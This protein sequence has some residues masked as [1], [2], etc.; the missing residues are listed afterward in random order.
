MLA[1]LFGGEVVDV[2]F[3]RLNE[4]QSPLVELAEVVGGVAEALPLEAEPA[5]VGHDGVDVLLL[6]LF[7]IG[8][9]E[10]QVGFAAELVGETEVDADGLGVA[11]VQVAV[12]LGRKARLDRRRRRTFWCAHPRRSCR[13]GSWRSA[14]VLG[15][16]GWAFR[17]C[18]GHGGHFISFHGRAVADR[19]NAYQLLILTIEPSVLQSRTEDSCGVAFHGSS[20]KQGVSL[21]EGQPYASPCPLKEV[22][23]GERE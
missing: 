2:G 21:S 22:L 9:V 16:N 13:G 4:L 11:D 7:G 8:V 20:D 3:A 10:A 19:L 6:F 15:W 1:D 12:G 14:G 17:I 23:D 18:V 5:H